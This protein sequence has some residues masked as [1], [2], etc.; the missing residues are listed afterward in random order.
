MFW[1]NTDGGG[2]TVNVGRR[3]ATA[4]NGISVMYSAGKILNFGGGPAFSRSLSARTGL[5]GFL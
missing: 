5:S 3:G 2:A 1:I 4:L